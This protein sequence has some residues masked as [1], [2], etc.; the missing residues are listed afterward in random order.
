[1]KVKE[2]VLKTIDTPQNRVRIAA[3]MG[4]G[5][6]AVRKYIKNNDPKLTQFAALQ[7]IKAITGIKKETDILE[8]PEFAKAV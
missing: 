3:A 1:M 6:Q 5:E 2:D 8:E 7:A 4:L